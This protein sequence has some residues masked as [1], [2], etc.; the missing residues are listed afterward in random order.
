MV[1]V[2]NEWKKVCDKP[3]EDY[4]EKILLSH[5]IGLRKPNPEIFSYVCSLNNLVPKDTLFID[6][7]PQH[8]EGASS[9]GLQT[10]YLTDPEGLY[11]VFS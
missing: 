2:R 10:I 7:S 1:K 6:D 11:D 5:E 3:M 9:I 4:F 8:I